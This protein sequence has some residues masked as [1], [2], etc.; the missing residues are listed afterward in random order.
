MV[1]RR[2]TIITMME[3]FDYIILFLWEKE[4]KNIWFYFLPKNKKKGIK[5]PVSSKVDIFFFTFHAKRSFITWLGNV[6][7]R[8][9]PFLTFL[10]FSL[11]SNFSQNIKKIK[12]YVQTINIIIFDVLT[13]WTLSKYF[14]RRCEVNSNKIAIV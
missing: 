4:K 3:F 12:N 9:K 7:D 2:L 11:F 10:L 5:K 1:V 13:Q 14:R 6:Q 8:S